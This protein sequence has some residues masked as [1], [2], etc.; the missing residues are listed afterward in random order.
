M[1]LYFK[2]NK[3]I[4]LRIP[5]SVA[6]QIQC[7]TN[8][9]TT[10][11]SW[12]GDIIQEEEDVI[13][14]QKIYLFPQVVTSG[15]FRTDTPQ[16]S[17]MYDDWYDK[18]LDEVADH[19]DKTGES[20]AIMQYNGHSH[21]NAACTPSTE[22]V[23]FR[24]SREGFNVYS[25]HN[26]M[27]GAHWEIWT[28]D[29]VYEGSDIDIIYVDEVFKDAEEFILKPPAV[30]YAKPAYTNPYTYS[31]AQKKITEAKKKLEEQERE[32]E[33]NKLLR[34]DFLWEQAIPVNSNPYG[35]DDNY[36]EDYYQRN[37]L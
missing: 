26:K 5:A 1:T 20:K 2:N 9:F 31:Q 13:T 36:L 10:E 35:A 32:A 16:V 22:D 25:I 29:V 17:D 37:Q 7:I 30:S 18:K 6:G 4:T 19:F 14:I 3:L 27:G 21:V 11:V 12:Y 8:H 34:D 28:D 15:T 23:K 33:E 24:T